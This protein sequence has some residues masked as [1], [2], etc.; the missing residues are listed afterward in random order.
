MVRSDEGGREGSDEGGVTGEAASKDMTRGTH[1]TAVYLALF[2][3]FKSK[4]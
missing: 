1:L 4:I 3:P 2:S